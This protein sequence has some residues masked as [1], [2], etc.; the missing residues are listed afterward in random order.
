MDGVYQTTHRFII[1]KIYSNMACLIG[2][3]DNMDPGYEKIIMGTS[4]LTNAR[5]KNIVRAC[6]ELPIKFAYSHKFALIIRI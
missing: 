4:R 2:T 5:S 1:F 6:R 3:N